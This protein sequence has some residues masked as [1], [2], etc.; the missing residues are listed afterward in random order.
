MSIEVLVTA[1]LKERIGNSW[2]VEVR[3]G[4]TCRGAASPNWFGDLH[5]IDD[6]TGE[7]T[8][9]GGVSSAS[10]KATQIV[11]MRPKERHVHPRLKLQ[12][13]EDRA[14]FHSSNDVIT[15]GNT[16]IVPGLDSDGLGG[17]GSGG[18]GGGGGGS[19]DPTD[20]LR[21]GGCSNLVTGTDKGDRLAGGA[22]GDL[23]F[24]FGGAD[25]ITG[26]GGHDCLIG[27]NGNDTLR[28]EGGYDRLTG[29]AG[30]DV[31]V[32][33]AG[34]NAYDAG[35]GNDYVN[36]RNGR[37]ERVRCG[38]GKDRARVDKRDRTSSCE[39]VSRPR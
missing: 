24:G 20:P 31:L 34:V 11:A 28:G 32:G 17:G 16:V 35:P 26:S 1:S 30:R 36:A 18:G 27:G 25:R 6:E 37:R 2:V 5:L 22:A 19:G 4:A 10:G 9:M 15:D 8:Y 7:D 39:R 23:I 29:G 14:P 21:G 33:G 38:R 13:S 3:W 12:C